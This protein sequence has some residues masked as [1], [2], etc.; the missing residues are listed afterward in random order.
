MGGWEDTRDEWEEGKEGERIERR[1][2]GK[3]GI[4]G[5][6]EGRK[7]KRRGTRKRR[8]EKKVE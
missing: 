6:E 1:G 3:G 4:E 5:K 2:K 8:R 7:K